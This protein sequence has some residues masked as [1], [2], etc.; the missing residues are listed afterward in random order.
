[1][2][3]STPDLKKSSLDIDHFIQGNLALPSLPEVVMRAYEILRDPHACAADVGQ[4]ISED[5]ALTLRL[6]KIVN[7]PYYGYPSR[8]HTVSRAVTVIG[9]VELLDMLLATTVIKLF[10]GIPK[11]ALNMEQFW[12]HSLY[13]GAIA[14]AI[15]LAK[16]DHRPEQYFV[17]GLLHDIGRL[18]IV[19]KNANAQVQAIAIA[20]QENISLT[21]AE[22]KVLGFSHAAVGGALSRKWKLPTA[23]GIAM[24]FHH[25][26][27]AAKEHK[28]QAYATYL[29]NILASPLEL[30]LQ[31]D[32]LWSP[33]GVGPEIQVEVLAK[34]ERFFEEAKSLLEN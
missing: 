21:E 28:E 1:M 24:E 22:E 7:S 15:A 9:S 6:L 20:Q 8:I 32:D 26:P 5:A 30:S 10:A 17:G 34:A 3:S 11:T 16:N 12:H 25:N 27:W 13:C 19:Q 4:V 18:V 33:L 23:L 29:A 2:P 14:K 31:T